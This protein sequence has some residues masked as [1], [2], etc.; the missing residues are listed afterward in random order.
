M[1]DTSAVTGLHTAFASLD[2]E[3]L[4]AAPP[5]LIGFLPLAVYACDASGRIRWFN[6]KAAALWGRSPEIGEK[7][8]RLDG[9]GKVYGLDG[10]LI[11]D[12]ESP[13]ARAL[14]TGENVEGGTLTIERPDGSRIAATVHVTALRDSGRNIVGAIACFHDVTARMREDR[15]AREGERRLRDILD[16][17]PVA[18]YTTDAEG[19]ITYYNEAAVEMSGRRPALGDDKWCVSW[20]LFHPDGTPLAHDECPMATALRE[21]R[22]VRGAEAVAQRPDGSRVP[23]I[24]YPTPLFDPAGALAGAVNVLVDIGHRKEAE[25]RQRLLFGELNHRIKNNMQMLYALLAAARRETDGEDARLA[26]DEASRRVAAMAA[27]QTA[28]YQSD[29]LDR[30]DSEAFMASVCA[31]AAGACGDEVRLELHCEARKLANDMAVPLA[32][33]LNELV[34]N[35]AKYGA[36][37]EG[38]TTIRVSLTEEDGRFLLAVEDEGPGFDLREVRRKSSGLGLVA[39]L[40]RQVGGRFRVERRGGARCLLE[41]SGPSGA[42]A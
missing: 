4:L 38:R 16:A 8:E 39:G 42:S 25:T 41:F 18:L 21:Q 10:A 7:A 13:M 9:P 35:A 6:G 30:F 19:R 15:A 36:D 33:I 31:A 20:K 34:G 22:A 14:R 40:A 12:G 5:A 29:D 2:P 1:N 3:P 27:A 37:A 23:F 24:P 32:L 28:L 17:L 11:S 26:L